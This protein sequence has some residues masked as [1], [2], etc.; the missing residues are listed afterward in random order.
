MIFS[1]RKIIS[2]IILISFALCLQTGCSDN[3]S[4]DISNVIPGNEKTSASSSDIIADK[5]DFD[6]TSYES[7]EISGIEKI[8]EENAF[9]DKCQTFRFSYLSDSYNI[10]AYISI[11]LSCIEKQE[12]CR[13]I[14]Y[15]RGG[16]DHMGLLGIHDTEKFCAATGRIVIASQYRGA[17][18]AQGEDQF[19]GDD[20]RDVAKLID[21]CEK[22]FRFA[23]MTDFC[24]AGLSRGGMMSYMTAKQDSRI[25]KMVVIS[26]V[27]DLISSYYDNTDMETMLHAA[28]GCSPEEAMD[29]YK[30]RSAVYWSE[31]IRIPVLIIHSRYDSLI[32]FEQAEV[33]YE[34]LRKTTD[35][36]FIRHEDNVH[37]IHHEDLSAIA[38]WLE[39]HEK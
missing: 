7:P 9:S 13:C 27:S 32:S 33:M 31:K 8:S 5:N 19:G 38:E 36:T 11:P 23:D 15:N 17:G 16:N 34:K 30:K 12:P 24:I 21:L 20:L 26:A 25:K 14:L 2:S 28:I 29:E 39:K 35:C 1:A 3:N 6:F 18:G 10:G 37:G 4:G 22:T